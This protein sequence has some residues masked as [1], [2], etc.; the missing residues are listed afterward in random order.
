MIYRGHELGFEPADIEDFLRTWASSSTLTADQVLAE[1]PERLIR[2]RAEAAGFGPGQT[3]N[4]FDLRTGRP[5]CRRRRS[6]K[7]SGAAPAATAGGRRRGTAPPQP[8]QPRAGHALRAGHPRRLRRRSAPAA[9][10]ARAALARDDGGEAERAEV[11][12][13]PSRPSKT[14]RRGWRGS[15]AVRSSATPSSSTRISRRCSTRVGSS[16]PR[17]FSNRADG[18]HSRRRPS[19]AAACPIKA[20]PAWGTARARRRRSARQASACGTRAS[21]RSAMRSVWR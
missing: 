15:R 11:A 7:R 4:F 20:W 21:R 1:M 9:R 17:R 8:D 16:R 18:S 19:A 5:N 3:Q 13:R 14:R 10:G 12:I 6:S 2:A